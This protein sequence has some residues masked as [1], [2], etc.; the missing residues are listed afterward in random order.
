MD[1]NILRKK[2]KISFIVPCY[3]AEKTVDETVNSILNLKLHDFEICLVDDGSADRTWERLESFQKK[4]SDVV[5]IGKNQE[6]HGGGYTRNR[7]FS[8]ST[9]PYIFCL[10]SDNVLHKESFFKLLDAASDADAMIAFDTIKFFHSTPFRWLKLCYK[11]LFF[12]KKEMAYGDLRKTLTHPVVGGNYLFKR[13]VFEKI[14]G[15]E[16]DLGAMDT[17]SFGYKALL[18]GDK[19]KIVPGTHYFHRV[20]LDS[21]WFRELDKNFENLKK[22]LLR[23]PEKF[24]A[25]EIQ[26][27]K[28]SKDVVKFLVNRKNDFFA[29]K[30]KFPFGIPLK[31]H[32]F[33]FLRGK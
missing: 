10:D 7:C 22:L 18:A 1:K 9:R 16:T 14:N 8:M 24:S 19:Y 25:E 28:D 15:Y 2:L 5:K 29:E 26:E 6:N 4:Y 17:W 21:Y 11:D 20:R 32:N 27:L 31:I 13:E 23:Y 12:L 30:I 3:N 33:L